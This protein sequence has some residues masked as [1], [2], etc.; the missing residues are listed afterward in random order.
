M[1]YSYAFVHGSY[2]IKKTYS[3][4]NFSTPILIDRIQVKEDPSKKKRSKKL[5]A[6]VSACLATYN[7][8]DSE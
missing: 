7:L 6:L 4:R 2:P 1:R 3:T 5:Q 8:Y